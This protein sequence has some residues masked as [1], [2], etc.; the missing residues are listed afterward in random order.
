MTFVPLAERLRPR[1]PDEVVGQADLLGSGRPLRRA[2]DSGR[3]PSMILW[4]PPG[5]GKT[6]LARLC[7]AAFDG[8]FIELSAV[9][10][11][12]EA[13]RAALE[14]ARENHARGVHTLLFVDEIHR[15][16]RVLQSDILS[17]VASGRLTLLGATTENPSFALSPALLARLQVHV[18]S[19]LPRAE[20]AHV[21]RRACAAEAAPLALDAGAEAALLRAADGDARRLLNLL[22][23]CIAA[24]QAAGR[25]ELDTR[26]V[27]P[28]LVPGGRRFDKGGDQFYD[29]ISALHKSV[30]G[31]SPDAA[32]YW[33]ARMLDG[34]AQPRYLARR[35]LAMAWDDIGLAD[36][37]AMRLASEAW[38]GCERLERKDAEL[39]LGEVAL[40]L[41]LADKSNAAAMAYS[42]AR[43]FVREDRAREVPPALCGG[44]SGPVS[45]RACLPDGMAEPGWYQPVPRGLEV[46]IAARMAA[47]RADGEEA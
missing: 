34:G 12:R 5:T 14:R 4:G 21:L 33:L 6:T 32:L 18:L 9:L 42:R 23:H 39:V 26:F 22:E 35:L 25:S 7:A 46:A 3:M 8:D 16:A 15:L 45:G 47:R 28:L 41:A 17:P 30:R 13:V 43:A 24:A 31:S 20:L 40:Y 1:R 44:A 10:A 36:P 37:R 19:V 38:S 27:T 2:L 11:G 29:Q